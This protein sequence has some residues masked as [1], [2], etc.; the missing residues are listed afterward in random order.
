MIAAVLLLAAIQGQAGPPKVEASVDRSRVDVGEEFT[1]TVH[2][3]AESAEPMEVLLAPLTGFEIVSR[4]EATQVTA[5]TAPS[6]TTTVSVQLRALRP[7]TWL[8]APAIARQGSQTGQSERLRVT[9]AAGSASGA[10]ALSPRVL[11]LLA[12]ARPPTAEQPV[13]VSLLFSDESV[14]VGEQVDVVTVAWFPRDLRLQMRRAPVLQPP[15]MEGAWSYPQPVPPGVADSRRVNG[16]VYDLFVMHQIVFPLVPGVLRT[17][18]ATLRYSVPLALQFFSQEERYTRTSGP[19]RLDVLPL[20]ADGRPADFEGAVGTSL[21]L[22]R[23]ASSMQA[24]VRRAFSVDFVLEGSGNVALWPAPAITW[25]EGLRAYPDHVDERVTVAD[26][27][28]GGRKTFSYLVVAESAGTF[29]LPGARYPFF[30]P[31]TGRYR[32]AEA[33]A[34]RVAV[35]PAG[36]ATAGRVAPP[37]LLSA[38]GAEPARA[39]TRALPLAGWIVLLL[40][41]PLAWAAQRVRPRRRAP[42]AP[43]GP[44]A[45]SLSSAER[46][47]DRLLASLVPS[48]ATR[49]GDGLP[50]ALRAAGVAEPL[51]ARTVAVR[52]RLLAQRYG[53]GTGTESAA[54]ADEALAVAAELGSSHRS[55]RA[56]RSAPATALGLALLVAVPISAAAAQSG[57]AAAAQSGRPDPMSLYAQGS[58]RAAAEGFAQQ[59]AANPDDPAHWYNLGAAWYRAGDDA[60]AAAAWIKAARLAPRDGTIR[61]ALRLVPSPDPDTARRTRALPLTP[62]ELALIAGLCWLA[63]WTV[64]LLR[65]SAARGGGALLAGAL[66]F[67][68]GAALAAREQS[69]PLAIVLDAAELRRSPH[70]RAPAIAPVAEGSAVRPIRREG[71]WT[72]A[73]APDARQGWLPLDVL[74]II[75]P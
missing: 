72:L 47:L 39:V 38:G 56:R 67:G 57:S 7:G 27:R 34:G 23:S 11:A 19:A 73:E 16:V 64:L 52:D 6:R 22:T 33:I 65:P 18:G 29:A 9:V 12:R 8:L 26:G 1:Y 35:A 58:V 15:A 20:P 51:V 66:V 5:G 44:V 25:P 59:A 70:H 4:S 10:T 69:R 68:I 21:T 2:A 24:Q 31:V 3:S 40:L 45:A 30:D 60:R 43:A 32:V 75:N 41:P 37:P 28:L 46:A 14:R 74:S 71:G 49:A 54:L 53:P 48:A 61:R 62:P 36:E 63:G 13:A 42:A 55:R 50:A 17:D